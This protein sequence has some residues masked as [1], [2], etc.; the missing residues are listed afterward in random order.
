M[1]S[2]SDEKMLFAFQF[3]NNEFDW[4][5]PNGH[6]EDW[7][8]NGKKEIPFSHGE[9]YFEFWGEFYIVIAS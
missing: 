4:Y 6:P 1:M 7:M 9:Y 8:I 2:L 5:T 3:W